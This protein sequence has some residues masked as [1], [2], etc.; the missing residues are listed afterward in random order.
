MSGGEDDTWAQPAQSDEHQGTGT[1]NS[2]RSGVSEPD[3]CAGPDDAAH[4]RTIAEGDPG[5]G[6]RHPRLGQ[7]GGEAGATNGDRNAARGCQEGNRKPNGYVRG[8]CG[9]AF[10]EAFLSVCNI[11]AAVHQTDPRITGSGGAQAGSWAVRGG[12]GGRRT[13]AR[14]DPH[15][16]RRSIGATGVCRTPTGVQLYTPGDTQSCAVQCRTQ[17]VRSISYGTDRPALG[18]SA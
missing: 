16:Y 4:S 17:R 15:R 12:R 2:H 13:R 7:P 10:A 1:N 18:V 8:T 9:A 11:S 14:A 5:A 6:C 3:A